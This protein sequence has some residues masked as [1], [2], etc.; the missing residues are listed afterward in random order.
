MRVVASV[1]IGADEGHGQHKD[2]HMSYRPAARRTTSRTSHSIPYLLRMP[3]RVPR[4]SGAL[5]GHRTSAVLY[6]PLL[7]YDPHP[8]PER[9]P[10]GFHEASDPDVVRLNLTTEGTVA[11]LD[12]FRCWKK[13]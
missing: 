3:K 7:P 8:A 5:G 1:V 9:P 13:S 6:P 4:A 11:I 10:C 12:F 2:Q